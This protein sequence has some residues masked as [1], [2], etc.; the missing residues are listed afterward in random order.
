MGLTDPRGL[1]IIAPD[2]DGTTPSQAMPH[3]PQLECGSLPRFEKRASY[4]G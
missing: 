2:P 1:H 3:T 4:G